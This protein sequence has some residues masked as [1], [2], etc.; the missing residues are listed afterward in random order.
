MCCDCHKAAHRCMQ[1]QQGSSLT[2]KLQTA[3]GFGPKDSIV[4]DE[5]GVQIVQE[6]LC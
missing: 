5:V 1:G 3:I 6:T 4:T 2:E